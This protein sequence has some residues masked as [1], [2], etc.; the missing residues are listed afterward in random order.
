MKN[1]IIYKDGKEVASILT[2][3]E[4]NYTALEQFLI[5]NEIDTN[6]MDENNLNEWFCECDG[7][8]YSTY[9]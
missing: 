8:F 2:N 9:K 6:N 1:T 5:E 7:V 4:T 3:D